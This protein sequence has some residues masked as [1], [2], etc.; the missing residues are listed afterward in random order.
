MNIT[1]SHCHL[2]DK[3][4]HG[5]VQAVLDRARAAGVNRFVTV[6]CGPA[7]AAAAVEL[8]DRF[9]DVWAAAGIHPHDAKDYSEQAF[10]QIESLLV[11]PRVVALGEIG[12]DYHYDFSPRP[13]QLAAFEAQL[14]HAHRLGLPV[15]IHCREA[16]DDALE[17]IGRLR[18]EGVSIRGVFHCY[19][20][21]PDE[22][23][24]VLDA[25]FLIS[26]AGMVTFK[27]SVELQQVARLVPADHLMVETDAP[28]LSPES[29]RKVRPN[30][31]AFVA[32]T[33][34]F[35]A[36]LRG[37]DASQLAASTAANSAGLF[38]L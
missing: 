4:L 15:I 24:R 12:L 10:E 6:G 32:H 28:Y 7:D 20:G 1:D 11:R 23:V 36:D 8:A 9:D 5:D 14:R 35:L 34:K 30:E 3:R 22:A 31:P 33:L 29:V 2:T 27:K 37:E 19:T 13:P 17:L 38:G 18:S 21:T 16:V 25:G 26:L